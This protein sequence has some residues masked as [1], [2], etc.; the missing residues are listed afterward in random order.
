[1]AGDGPSRWF[2]DVWSRFYDW[3]PVQWATYRPVHDAVLAALEPFRG[4]RILDIGC[5]TGRLSTRLHRIHSRKTI[6]G[7]DFSAGM[8]ERAAARSR[9]VRW[10]RGDAARLPFRD[11]VF[12]AIVSTEAFHWFP[13]QPAALAELFR[14]LSP[15][16][17]LLVALVNT[18]FELSSNVVE[19]A[20]R[21]FGEPFYWPTVAEMRRRVEEAGFHVVRQQRVLR[22]PGMLFPPVLTH[23]IKSP[24]RS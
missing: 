15:G 7:C 9:A 11:H 19:A 14:V 4:G 20:S 16:G 5:G 10:V 21:L 18:R 24:S 23:A 13:D 12:G 1:M 22:F 6:I 17:L 2:F 3:P 8:L